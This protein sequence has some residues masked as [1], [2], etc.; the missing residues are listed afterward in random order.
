MRG[1]YSNRAQGVEVG[2]GGLPG[3]ELYHSVNRQRSASFEQH[4]LTDASHRRLHNTHMR[5][6][7]TEGHTDAAHTSSGPQLP[8]LIGRLLGL[9]L[10]GDAL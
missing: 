6:P 1:D 2:I 4:S 5:Q 8:A 9:P 10:L 3:A 7:P